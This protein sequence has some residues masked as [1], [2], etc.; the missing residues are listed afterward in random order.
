MKTYSG[1]SLLE[2]DTLYNLGNSLYRLG[3]KE[4][5][6]K[7]IQFWKEAIGN[8]TKSLALRTDI[9][10]E[11]NLAFVKEKIK[12]E[13]KKQEENKKEEQKT[14][15]GSKQNSEKNTE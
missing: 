8:Y 14:G 10:T 6:Q 15:S 11:E 12:Q 3:E 2:A 9:Q 1:S 7:R 13:E 4:E 5:N